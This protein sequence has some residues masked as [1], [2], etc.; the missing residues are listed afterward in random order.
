MRFLRQ[1][2]LRKPY[3]EQKFP[4][5]SVKEVNEDLRLL[6]YHQFVSYK[7]IYGMFGIRRK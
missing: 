5:L 2:K 7:N 6:G 4:G 1:I 3:S